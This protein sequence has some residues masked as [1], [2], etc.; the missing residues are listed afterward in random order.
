MPVA[1]VHLFTDIEGSTRLWEQQPQRMREA[2][3]CHDALARAAVLVHH[4]RVVKTTGDGVHAV[5][6]DPADAV[7]ATLGLLQALTDPQATAGL[8]LAVRCGIHAGA[9]E[10]RD[11]DYFGRDVNR[12][13]RIM[14]AAHG[15]QLLVSQ[16]VAQALAGRLPLGQGLRDLGEVRLRDLARA[17]HLFQLDAPPLRLD[18]PPLRSLVSSPSNLPQPLNR[19]IGRGAELQQLRGLLQ[20]HR[21]VT[22]W[23][24]G[25]I[26]KSRLSLQIGAERL[27]D[28]SDGVW[29][30]ELAALSDG[31]HVAQ[32]VAAVLGVKEAPG[33]SLADAL[34]RHVSDRQLLLILDNCEHVLADAAALA[35]AVLQAGPRLRLLASSRELLH[36]A[37][38][39]ALAV[40]ALS[41]PAPT[42]LA[43]E[44][45]NAE[46]LMQHEAVR[47][48]V[49]RAAAVQPKFTLD[50]A[51]AAA[52]ADICHRLDGI[53]LAIELAA[54]RSGGLPVQL[55]AQRL[56]ES[57]AL[58]ATRDST[59]APRQRT[60]R[61]LIDWSH[62]LLGPAERLLY[63]RLA[64]FAGGLSLDA[65]EQVCADAQLPA[66]AVIELLS[67]L[68]DKSL[69]SV[70]LDA[71]G[72]G[73][74]YRLL[75]TVRRHA[76]EHL[77]SDEAALARAAL[78]QRHAHWALALAE[79]AR[80]QLAGARQA[81]WLARL[82]AE[83]ENLLA[84]FAWCAQAEE[85]PHAPPQ[86]QP[87]TTAE[88]PS[89]ARA[90]AELGLRLSFALRPYWFNRGLLSMGLAATRAVLALPGA[91]PRDSQRARGLFDAGQICS[92]MGAYGQAL[93]HLG[94][95]LAIAR[96]TGDAA[97]EAAVLQPMVMA[98]LGLG[99]RAAA[100]RHGEAAVQAAR[101][102]DN[103][104][105]LAAACNALAQLERTEGRLDAAEALYAEFLATARTLGDPEYT[106]IGLLN[107]AMVAL[108]RGGLAP[109]VWPMLLQVMAIADAN[110]SRPVAL[111]V[112]D[113]A[114]GLAAQTG[115]AARAARCFGLS[116]AQGLQASLQR[117]AADEALLRPLLQ[118][119][120]AAL[121]AHAFEA[122]AQ[123]GQVAAL[124][125][126]WAE[127]RL[128]LQAGQGEPA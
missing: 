110:G 124:D 89:A 26:G 36:V 52:V 61:L 68:V 25:G 87:E 119:A 22:L 13:A 109:R 115:D 108:A 113:V 5:F 46:A 17:E 81:E 41:A 73:W 33:Q 10:L 86:P 62:E 45:A 60:L 111:C 64:V 123:A 12:A 94:D 43:S 9:D 117:D 74:R 18:F 72:A 1:A 76:A 24:P 16:P 104:R 80:P 63:R 51:N 92:F 7:A 71:P 42:D 88:P 57:F 27:A 121:G 30:V 93:Q 77:A 53:P 23:G 44:Q 31:T 38:E 58:V 91:A 98:A 116:E 3:A 95:S 32:A 127:L 125:A 128:W 11:N 126:V 106:A 37:G 102:L 107:Q 39:Q 66:S 100:R 2:L 8:A 54:A 82:D 114:A 35:K 99:D 28:F 105:Q 20:T 118:Q 75:D 84:A 120:R 103:P 97:R 112:L 65:A 96:E 69:L 47:L 59:V 40:P 70:Q 48:F 101:A 122:H 4:G 6:S 79:T 78:R 15:G 29:L 34:A 19:F 55:I 56:R 90:A 50:A 85:C 67:Q 14:S 83:R 49:D 21:L